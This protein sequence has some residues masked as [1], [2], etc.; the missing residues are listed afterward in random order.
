MDTCGCLE[1]TRKVLSGLEPKK[2]T[3][4]RYAGRQLGRQMHGWMNE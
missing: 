2:Y 4:D 1:I 3:R